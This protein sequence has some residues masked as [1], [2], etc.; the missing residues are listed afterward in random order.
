MPGPLATPGR[1]IALVEAVCAVRAQLGR[2]I[3]V[4]CPAHRG[5]AGNEAADAVAKAHL[6]G[7]REDTAAALAP[8]LRA[9]RGLTLIESEYGADWVH[10]EK[11]FYRQ[12]KASMGRWI[13]QELL[14][15][16]NNLRY[17]E[18]MALD[19]STNYGQGR[20]CTEVLSDAAVH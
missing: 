2:V 10:T 15:T 13:R 16:T 7:E 12:V 17:D 14:K 19:K 8:H 20:Y 1:L 6:G 5:I 3:L 9:K 18:A 11:R 4:Y